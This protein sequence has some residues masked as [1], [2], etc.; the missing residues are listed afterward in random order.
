[1]D[2]SSRSRDW[3]SSVLILRGLWNVV[4]H[5]NMNRVGHE[6]ENSQSPVSIALCKLKYTQNSVTFTLFRIQQQQQK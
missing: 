3:L 2:P 6:H 1:M 5:I 4:R